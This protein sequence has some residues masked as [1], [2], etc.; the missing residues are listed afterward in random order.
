[1]TRGEQ[2]SRA[3]LFD[4]LYEAY[5]KA[6]HAYLLG[7]T[8]DPPAA[9]DLLQETFLRVWR[10]IHKAGEL[11][12]EKQRRW[13]FRIAKN[14]AVGYYRKQGRKQEAALDE[15]HA[16]PQALAG[17]DLDPEEAYTLRE[18]VREVDR[19]LARLP[20]EL[21]VPL[22]MQVVGQMTSGQIARVLD[23]PPGTVRYQI[24]R[25]RKEL[26]RLLQEDGF[27]EAGK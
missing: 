22:V 21:R 25:A 1:M 14:V 13:V 16:Q 4:A 12:P 9:L 7:R 17:R 27:V 23:R 26:E 2:Q 11:D 19:A 24:H 8:N 20:E 6:V 15:Q 3:A 18:T 5:H 10:H